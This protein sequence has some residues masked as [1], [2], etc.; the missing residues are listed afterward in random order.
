MA[1]TTTTPSYFGQSPPRDRLRWR[2]FQTSWLLLSLFTIDAVVALLPVAESWSRSPLLGNRKSSFRAFQTIFRACPEEHESEALPTTIAAADAAVSNQKSQPQ[3][4][5]QLPLHRRR[6][7]QGIVVAVATSAAFPVFPSPSVAYTPDPDKLQESLYFISRVQEATVQQERFINKLGNGGADP[8]QLRGKLKL[9]LR[10]V[11]KNYKLLD[12]INFSSAYITPADMLVEASEAGY[13]AVDALQGAI[14][15]VNKDG[16]WND[17]GKD[18]DK[19]KDNEPRTAFLTS[20]MQTCREQLLVYTSYM[21]ADKLKNARY[22]VEDENVKNREEF[23]GDDDAGVYN[24]VN[25]P[26]KPVLP[27][28]AAAFVK[29]KGK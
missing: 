29:G 2:C 18:K 3:S 23:D 25:L 26:W 21:P 14:E 22:R 24:P 11:D 16:N 7:L 19:D 4:S 17:N 27:A 15:Y 20:S 10:L 8:A 5:Q 9:T 12:Q 1:T 28:T 13:E 6:I